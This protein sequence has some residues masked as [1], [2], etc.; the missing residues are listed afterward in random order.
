[1]LSY[2]RSNFNKVSD[3]YYIYFIVNMIV[4]LK[5]Y[6]VFMMGYISFLNILQIIIFLLLCYTKTL[7]KSLIKIHSLSETSF[8]LVQTF[9]HKR[10]K[11]LYTI[12]DK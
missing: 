3:K 7:F 5:S 1:M 2:I 9:I 6:L 4:V 10:Q 8:V 11:I 12:R